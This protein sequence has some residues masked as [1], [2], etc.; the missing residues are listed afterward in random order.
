MY[1]LIIK[2]L[3][4][5]FHNFRQL[6]DLKKKMEKFNKEYSEE[7]K[8]LHHKIET[9]K[10]EKE[11]EKIDNKSISKELDNL[12]NELIKLKVFRLKFCFHV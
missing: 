1:F 10:K 12:R 5:Y 7:K 9:E 8:E 3:I 2:I 6:K 4:S 11:K